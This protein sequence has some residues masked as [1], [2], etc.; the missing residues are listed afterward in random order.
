MFW[1]RQVVPLGAALALA[2][3]VTAP[4]MS[5]AFVVIPGSTKTMAEFQQDDSIC[6]QHASALTGYGTPAQNAT[7]AVPS[8]AGSTSAAP[9][10]GTN[11][12]AAQPPGR[13]TSSAAGTGPDKGTGPPITGQPNEVAYDQCMAARGNLVQPAPQAYD[14]TYA[15]Y[16]YPYD[17]YD[18]GFPYADYYDGFYGGWGWGV[19]GVFVY[20]RYHHGPFFHDRFHGGGY[21]RF[22]YAGLGHG[23]FGHGGFGHGGFGHGGGGH[24]GGG[25]GGGHR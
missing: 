17:Y 23:G 16:G 13:T 22:A 24:S 6:R 9:P 4:P 7:G 11:N 3:C 8:G 5:P 14:A 15:G 12:S 1:V 10:A 25:S 21:G 20:D 2:G 19:G 18:F